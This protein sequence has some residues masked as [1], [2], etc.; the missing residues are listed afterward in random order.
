MRRRVEGEKERS[1]NFIKTKNVTSREADMQIH[2][3]QRFP[4]RLNLKKSALQSNHQKSKTKRNLKET[5]EPEL[6]YTKELP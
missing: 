2:E 4:N 3:T 5:R 1:R 6:I